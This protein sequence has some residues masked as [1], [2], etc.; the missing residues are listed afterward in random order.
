MSNPKLNTAFDYQYEKLAIKYL[1]NCK[2][3]MVRVI[4][5][6][7]FDILNGNFTAD[8]IKSSIMSL[9]SN[10]SP[11]IDYIPAE[12]LKASVYIISYDVAELFNYVIENREFP[13]RWAIG[14]RSPI[15]K[16]GMKINTKKMIAELQCYWYLKNYSKFLFKGVWNL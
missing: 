15:Y 10:K 7:E 14:L 2:T 4:N 13:D 3:N 11:G 5:P 8:E 12:F 9:K 6:I 1:E 16:S